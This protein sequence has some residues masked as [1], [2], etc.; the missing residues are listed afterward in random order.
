MFVQ[1]LDP[2]T[3]TATFLVEVIEVIHKHLEAKW[4]TGGL[5]AMPVLP[6]VV[7]SA[8]PSQHGGAVPAISRGLSES[9]SDT[10]G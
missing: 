8:A 7:A 10:P 3:G 2:A 4:K 1:I 5:T 6:A 9:A